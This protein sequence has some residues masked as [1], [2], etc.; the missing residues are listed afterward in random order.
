MKRQNSDKLNKNIRKE[1]KKSLSLIIPF[2]VLMLAL[3]IGASAFLIKNYL[4]DD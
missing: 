2:A 4:R 3:F 1:E